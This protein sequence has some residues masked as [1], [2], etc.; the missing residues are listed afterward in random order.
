MSYDDIQNALIISELAQEM[1]TEFPIDWGD[2]NISEQ[3]AYELVAI[4]VLANIAREIENILL[5]IENQLLTIRI[6]MTKDNYEHP[7]SGES[8]YD[9][10]DKTNQIPNEVALNTWNDLMPQIQDWAEA[11]GTLSRS[12]DYYRN[13]CIEIGELLGEEV[14]ICDDGTK[15]EDVLVAKL[16]EVLKRK[17]NEK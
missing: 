5:N 16:V 11:A 1:E 17:L 14:Y 2:L 10:W 9:Y 7:F 13:I 6:K 15:S 8:F 12:S 3:Q 4:T